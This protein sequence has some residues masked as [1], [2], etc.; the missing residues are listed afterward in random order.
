MANLAFF[1]VIFVTLGSCCGQP[2]ANG[3]DGS[4]DYDFDEN[5]DYELVDEYDLNDFSREDGRQDNL[6]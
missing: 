2:L 1:V 3:D 5:Y 4:D 6:D